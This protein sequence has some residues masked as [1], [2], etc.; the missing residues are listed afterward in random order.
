MIYREFLS[1]TDEEIIFILNDIFHPVKIENIQR[2]TDWNTIDADM[3]TNG[4]DDGEDNNIEI[5]DEITLN[6]NDIDTPFSQDRT[7]VI[8]WKKYLLAKGCN[9]LLKDNP[10]L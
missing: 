9:S 5:T 4:W 6:L 3:T 10:Y 8:Q 2:N 7:D 1:L